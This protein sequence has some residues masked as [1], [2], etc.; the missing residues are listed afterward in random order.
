MNQ[1]V[2]FR[3]TNIFFNSSNS[4]VFASISL[5][6][7][8]DK[9]C[10]HPRNLTAHTKKRRSIHLSPLP[11]LSE[12]V[13]WTQHSLVQEDYNYD[14]RKFA[15]FPNVQ[16]LRN[17]P[18]KELF[19]KVVM[20]RFDTLVILQGMKDHKPLPENAFSTIKY[21]YDS[22]AKVILVGSW[23]ESANPKFN[24]EGSLSTKSVA[25]F[26]SSMLELEVVPVKHVSG[27]MHLD[28]DDSKTPGILLIENLFC[29]KG[30]RANC[31]KFAK[32]LV[33]GVD[34]I[35]NDAF[36]ESHKVLAS[37]VGAARFCYAC[38]AGF[39]FE[40]GLYKLKKII[41]NT[42]RPY[43]AIIGGGKLA[44]KAAALQS[45][46]STCDGLVFVGTMAFQILHALGAPIPMKFVETGALE[47]ATRIVESAKLRNIP[48]VL[49]QDVWC[50][51]DHVSEEI[52]IASVH[53]IPEG[54]QPVDI[55]PRSLEEITYFLSESKAYP[56][57]I[58]WSVVYDDPMRPLIVDVGSGNGLFLFGMGRRLEDMNFLG[59]E[60]NAKLVDR[61]LDDVHRLGIHN[62]HFIA[63]NAT[64]TFRS[65]V[66]SYPGDLVLV[67][68]QCP[69]PD[70]NKPQF[71][72]RMLQKSLVEAIAD[73]L[74][75]G[76]K[77]FLQ[78]DIEAVAMRMKEEFFIYGKGK[79]AVVEHS[80]YVETKEVGWL[81]ENPFGVP[82]DWERHVLDRGDPM[83]RLLLSK[84]ENK[85]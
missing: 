67:S 71:R 24:V 45:L 55:G 18:R 38:I 56:F 31:S 41:K 51:T 81:K 17:F 14:R 74:V 26:L 9:S 76:G 73:R 8:S 47:E 52:Q 65:I 22:R 62:V 33:S 16:S 34:I 50:I 12:L 85:G 39:Y 70:F 58:D 32:E 46:V 80:A 6:A 68:I 42:E 15:V 64:S 78:S 1:V 10:Y 13:D 5:K 30:E 21:L 54:W 19:G 44:D 4:Q 84:V 48:V 61:C 36:S 82:S 53:S 43:M 60:M 40:E 7:P 59:L 35:V 23:N 3:L 75:C 69:N 72:W 49:P 37:T 25:D 20:V 27:F 66:S 11:A 77:V 2:E 57:L 83:Y 28:V 29:F 63:T 79:L